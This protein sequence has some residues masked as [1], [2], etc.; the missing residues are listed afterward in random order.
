MTYLLSHIGTGRGLG[1][2]PSMNLLIIFAVIVLLLAAN[3]LY[4]AAEFAAVS[5]RRT[6]IQERAAEGN[7]VARSLLSVLENRAELDRYIAACQVG[8]TLSSLVI[9]F[10]GQAQLGP[11]LS[12]LFVRFGGL[13]EAAA[14]SVSAIVVLL[15]LTT[16]QVISRR[17]HAQVRRGALPRTLGAHHHAADARVRSGFC[18]P[19]SGF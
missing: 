3:A 6:R 9:G 7:R 2:S 4:V 13:Q 1:L 10:Y 18:A 15:L 11:Y 12:P 8:I 17:T 5:A 16:F 14:Y 19:S